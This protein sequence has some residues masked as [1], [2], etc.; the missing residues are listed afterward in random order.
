[1]AES[2]N[3]DEDHS[4]D[5]ESECEALDQ[6]TP[7]ARNTSPPLISIKSPYAP[8]PSFK[9]SLQKLICRRGSTKSLSDSVFEERFEN[10]RRYVNGTYFLPNDDA[11]ETR[12]AIVHQAYLLLLGGKLT[13][14][15]I[16]DDVERILD[17]GAGPGEV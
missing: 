12:L 6:A 7:D 8:P 13:Y 3:D 9:V 4:I 10:G 1:M 17:L 5:E 2:S 15:R 16:P 11:E 14:S